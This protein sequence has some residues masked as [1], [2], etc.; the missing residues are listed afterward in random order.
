MLLCFNN[1]YS[2]WY[3][4]W[5]H[6]VHIIHTFNRDVAR[7]WLGGGGF[8]PPKLNVSPP[9]QSLPILIFLCESAQECILSHKIYLINFLGMGHSPLSRLYP[10]GTYGTSTPRLDA[11]GS[12]SRHIGGLSSPNSKNPGYVLAFWVPICD[13]KFTVSIQSRVDSM[14]KLLPQGKH[15]LLRN[16]GW[17]LLS[18]KHK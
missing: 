9:K 13:R 11:F 3:V 12:W 1:L 7:H 5:R 2:P 8:S 16:Y 10:L 14:P 18:R 15:F 6:I 17:C 4:F